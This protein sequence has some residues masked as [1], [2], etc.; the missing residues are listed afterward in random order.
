MGWRCVNDAVQIMGGESYMTENE[1]ERIFRDSRINLIVE[2]SNDLMQ[3][4]IFGYGGKKL[5]ESMLTVKDAVGWNKDEPFG[6]NVSRILKNGLKPAIMRAAVPLGL[7]LFLGMRRKAPHIK[8]VHPSLRSEADRLCRMV[9]EHSHQLKQTSKRLEEALFSRQAMQARLADMGIYLHAWA[10]TISKLDSDIRNNGGNGEGGPEFQRDKAA[11]MHFFD[12]CEVWINHCIRELYENSDESMTACATAAL[13]HNDTLP[14]SEFSIPERSP[15]AAGTG[16]KIKQ[17]GIKQ[18]P[19]N[20]Y[21][22]A[23]KL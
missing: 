18:F 15:I 21:A 3:G 9:R 13:K 19:G 6:Q 22:K 17:D 2:G 23:G 20:A 10:C 12:L 11:A 7:E 8:N 1:I 4:F 16:R 5:A 14:N